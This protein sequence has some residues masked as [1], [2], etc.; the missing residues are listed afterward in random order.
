MSILKKIQQPIF[1]RNVV[2]VA[3]PFF[4]VVTIF[5]LVLNSSKDIFSGNF[6]AV[7]ETNFS[8]GKWMRFWGLKFFISVTYGVWITN[9]K[10]A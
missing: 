5:S 7:N 3:I 10:M 1:W 9:K 4:I 8:N 6:N 2:K